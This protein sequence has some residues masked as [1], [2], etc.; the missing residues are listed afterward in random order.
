MPRNPH[1]LSEAE[2]RARSR[3]YIRHRPELYEIYLQLGPGRTIPAAYAELKRRYPADDVPIHQSTVDKWSKDGHWGEKARAHD[4]EL[5]RRE[6][7][8]IL[9][10]ADQDR[11][12]SRVARRVDEQL[13]RSVVRDHLTIVPTETLPDGTTVRGERRPRTEKEITAR[14]LEQ[15]TRAW[16][17]A[18]QEERLD[19]GDVTARTE[20]TERVEVHTEALPPRVAAMPDEELIE[21]ITELV[22]G[23]AT[24]PR[25]EA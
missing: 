6:E 17:R 14:D 25:S 21:Y 2:R 7:Q 10:E 24:L 13:I 4:A 11:I 22:N 3:R 16:V 18:V 1:P 23:G 9:E 12:R 8:R 19:V 5:A 15:A 20:S